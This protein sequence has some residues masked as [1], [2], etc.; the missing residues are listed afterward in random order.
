MSDDEKNP[1][2]IVESFRALDDARAIKSQRPLENKPVDTKP[3]YVGPIT[4][5]TPAPPKE[6]AK[7]K[8]ST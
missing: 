6:S 4:A 1:T 2:V 3:V 8:G 7:D 5:V